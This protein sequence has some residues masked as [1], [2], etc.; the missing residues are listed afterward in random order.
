MDVCQRLGSGGVEE[1][2]GHVGGQ[3]L[4]RDADR[5]CLGRPLGIANQH[6]HAD[7][8]LVGGPLVDHAV[9]PF[10]QAVVSEKHKHRVVEFARFFEPV[11]QSAHA[12]IDGEN[13]APVGPHH[14]GEVDNPAGLVVGEVFPPVE[15]R[16]VDAMPG[17]EPLRDPLRLIVEMEG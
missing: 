5:A 3:H 12:V 10:E 7:A 9:L 6:R 15:D 17:G 14:A 8:R 2:G 4:L 1:S 16:P 13:C 11:E